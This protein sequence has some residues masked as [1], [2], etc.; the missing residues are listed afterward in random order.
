MA[1]GK[2]RPKF[3]EAKI[4]GLF[5]GLVV[6]LLFL[7]ILNNIVVFER[8]ETDLLDQFFAWRTPSLDSALVGNVKLKEKNSLQINPDIQIIGIDL[9]SLTDYGKWP[10]PRY[11]EADLVNAFTYMRGGDVFR[12]NSLFL[13]VFFAGVSQLYF[14]ESSHCF[15]L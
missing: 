2:K 11:R 10:F 14:S 7:V 15:M 12:E 4:F 6:F 1:E 9:R 5:I 8:I 13:D 3:F